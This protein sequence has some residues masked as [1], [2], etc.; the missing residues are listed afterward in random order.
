V[1]R[2]PAD[3]LAIGRGVLISVVLNVLLSLLR[4]FF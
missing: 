3:V 1:A 4:R 2:R